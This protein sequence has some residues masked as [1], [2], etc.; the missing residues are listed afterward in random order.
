MTNK[1]TV[2]ILPKSDNVT[3]EVLDNG[4]TLLIYENHNV[5][6]VVV[7]G[8]LRAGAVYEDRT[9]GG[10]AAMVAGALMSGTQYRDFATINSALEDIGAEFSY[11]AGTFKVGYN[12]KALAEDLPVLIDTLAD[13]L[14][15]PTFPDEQ[16]TRLRGERLTWLQYQQ[17]DT[18]WQSGRLFRETLY[19]PHHPFHYS[20]RGTVQTL[21][22]ITPEDMR[23]FHARHYGPDGMI[24][25]VVGAVESAAVIDLMQEKIGG[26]HNPHQPARP[27]LPEIA[28]RVEAQRVHKTLDGKTQSDIALGTTG[29]SRYATDYR[30]AVLANSIL[31][32]FGMMGRI[33]DVVREREGMAYYAYSSLDGGFGPGAWRVS[34]G[35]NPANV[36][37]AI[38]LILEETRRITTEPV[39]QEDLEDNQSYFTGRL[40]LQLETIEGVANI[41]HTIETYDLG[42]DYLVQYHDE[43]YALN[44]DDLLAAAARYLDP[45]KMVIATSGPN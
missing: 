30:A 31:G 44:P 36:E 37:R 18:R 33:G 6:S 42:L 28:A 2:S 17:Q 4:L 34:A 27:A 24:V 25:V 45:S 1:T 5:E 11:G 13:T 14:M 21:S 38:E 12:G 8:S 20:S 22:A 41:L 23:R 29:P 35:V 40:P 15:H 32:Q 10:T 26:W 39:S 3:R 7:D 19:P 9:R 43:I 16:V